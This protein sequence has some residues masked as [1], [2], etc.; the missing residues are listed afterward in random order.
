MGS[1]SSL[2][3]SFYYAFEGLKTAFKEEPNFKIHTV[4]ALA[5]LTL[6][7]FLN[8]SVSEWLLLLFT[9]SFVLIIELVNTSLEDIVNLVNPQIHPLAKKAKDVMA[10]AV[11]LS[12]ATA[13]VVGSVLFIPKLLEVIR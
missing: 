6:A 8:F 1:Q 10:A 9:I 7:F 11:L 3:K 5:V 2:L 4:I 13:A 12:A